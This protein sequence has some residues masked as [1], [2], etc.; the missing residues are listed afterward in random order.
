MKIGQ[1]RQR[2]PPLRR[3]QV[4][5]APILRKGGVHQRSKTAERTHVRLQLRR[6]GEAWQAGWSEG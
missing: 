4:A 6:E 2:P 3:N 5:T 1:S